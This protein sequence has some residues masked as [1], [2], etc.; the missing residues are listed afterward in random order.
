MLIVS[1]PA[2]LKPPENS[3]ADVAALR[4]LDAAANRA[5]EGL[6]VIE[7]YVRFVQDDAHLTGCLKRLRHD[8]ATQLESMS[9]A[10]RIAARETQRDV[11]TQLNTRSE[12]RRDDFHSIL[13]ANF[14]RLQQSLRSLEEYAKLTD[15]EAARNLERLRYQTY[16]LQRAVLITRQSL[17]RL[18]EARL[19]VL[20]DGAGSLT[21]L[22]ELAAAVIDGGADAIQLRDKVLDDRQLLERARL[23]RQLTRDAGKLLIVND[24]P[25]LAV[26][27]DADGV[28]VGQEELPVKDIRRLVGTDMLIGVSTHSIEQAR[29]AVLDGA[30]YLGVGPCFP[31]ATK[32][33]V[34]FPGLD[35]VKAVAGEICLPA[36]AI[37]GITAENLA[38]VAAAGLHRVA[39][40]GAATNADD[41][42]TA[43]RELLE[44]L[45]STA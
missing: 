21:Q 1:E 10:G 11:G 13:T 5:S 6:R 32:R 42:T 31:S 25:D 16:T 39:V 29:A 7:D 36:F 26:L 24:R 9:A 19:Y 44:R 37:G 34:E 18:A 43:C 14:Q 33:F 22:R 20:L 30:N 40:G 3:A 2:R 28:H 15:P 45:T 23:L 41:P 8:L 17:E 35:V 12:F 4:I 38:Q 27:S